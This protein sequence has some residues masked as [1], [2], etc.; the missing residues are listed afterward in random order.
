ML[1]VI[2]ALAQLTSQQ[3]GVQTEA[4]QYN[5]DDMV[6]FS[7]AHGRLCKQ[8]LMQVV[9]GMRGAPKDF[10]VDSNMAGIM[11]SRWKQEIF[12][13]DGTNPVIWNIEC[14]SQLRAERQVVV[15]SLVMYQRRGAERRGV[16]LLTQRDVR[17]VIDPR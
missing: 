1:F 12:R 9:P 10:D 16:E 8:T 13:P 17:I 5:F 4:L 6:S 11:T 2:P 7:E 3:T 15:I 14:V